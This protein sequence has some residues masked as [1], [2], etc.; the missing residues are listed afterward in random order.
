MKDQGD[1]K[2]EALIKKRSTLKDVAKL[3]GVGAGSVSRY[4]NGDSCIKAVN[5]DKIANA[6]KELDF[7]PNISARNLAKGKSRNI[8]LLLVS[9]SPITMATWIYEKEIVQEIYNALLKSG[10]N[11]LLSLCPCDQSEIRRMIKNNIETKNADAV[12]I[13]S[14]YTIKRDS[15]A[16]FEKNQVPYILIGSRNYKEKINEILIDNW[17]AIQIVIEYLISLKHK[18]I[19]FISGN[20]DQE[21]ME[22]RVQSYIALM[23]EKGLSVKP[24]YLRYGEFSVDGGYHCTK[25]LIQENI[26]DMPTAIICANDLIACGAIKALKEYNFKIPQEISIVG[27]DNITSAEM[28][29]PPLTTFQLL[30]G[31]GTLAIKMLLRMLKDQTI[32]ARNEKQ[33]KFDFIIRKSAAL[34]REAEN[35]L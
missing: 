33:V 18:K 4:L 22:S 30:N 24:E 29:E 6:I 7:V 28:I 1:V 26:S 14:N 25:E 2:E 16:L 11:L 17:S 19:A 21:Q 32:M 13:L 10:Y 20:K 23:A 9:E 35:T 31:A 8:L 15:I 12:I 27:F 3:A 34:S 5:R